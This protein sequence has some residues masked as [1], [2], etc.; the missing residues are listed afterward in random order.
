MKRKWDIDKAKNKRCIDEVI[1]RVEEIDGDNVG[2]IMAQDIVDI[3]AQ[4][5]GPEAYNLGVRDTKKL[6]QDKLQDLEFDIDLL[7]QD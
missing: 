4:Y 6:L 7:V 3:V 5:I 1:A 2:M